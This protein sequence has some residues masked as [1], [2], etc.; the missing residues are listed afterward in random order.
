MVKGR[1]IPQYIGPFKIKE[2]SGEVPYQL[3]LPPQFLV[4][5]D[6]LHLSQLKK[7]L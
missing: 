4:V 3:E 7:S 2:R 6:V 5:Q 1:G